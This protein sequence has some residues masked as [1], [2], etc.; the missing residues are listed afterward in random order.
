M[1]QILQVINNKTELYEYTSIF[2]KE[3][4]SFVIKD[5]VARGNRGTILVDKDV[6]GIEEYKGSQ[7]YILDG[8]ILMITL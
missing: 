7:K 8:S 4:D 3:R 6:D 1:Y 2:Y 5:A